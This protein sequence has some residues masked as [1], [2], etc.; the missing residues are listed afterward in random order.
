VLKLNN[1]SAEK[2]ARHGR[3][4]PTLSV[5]I[6]Q[7]AEQ[8]SIPLDEARNLI[9]MFGRDRPADHGPSALPGA[10]CG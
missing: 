8:N 7:F 2:D 4:A 5:L 10:A 6:E 3:T 9:A 1:G